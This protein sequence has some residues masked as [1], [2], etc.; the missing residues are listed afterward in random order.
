MTDLARTLFASEAKAADLSALA[1]DAAVK[2]MIRT[3][4]LIIFG[5]FA[6]IFGWGSTAHLD[7]AV[8]TFGVVQAEGSRKVVQHPD[9]GIINAILVKEGDLVQ[10][11]QI[12]I[13]LDPVQANAALNIQISDVDTLEASVAR[14]QAE[15]AGADKVVFPPDMTAR[16]ADPQVASIMATQNELF[17]ARHS[18]LV[19]D[20]GQLGEQVLQARSMADGYRG[21]MAAIDK[22]SSMIA[23]E[24]AGLQKLYAAGFATKPQVLAVER[25]ASALDGQKKEYMADI[26]RAGHA[27]GQYESQAAQLRRERVSD[28]SGQLEDARAK[29]ADAEQQKAAAQA[30]VDRT[31]IRAPATGFVFGLTANTIGAVIGRGEHIL[32]IVPSDAAPMVEAHLKPADGARVKKGM[33]VNLKVTASQGRALPVMSGVVKSRSVDLLSDE[34][35]G[36]AYYD[37]MIT[38]NRDDIVRAGAVLDVGTPVEVVVPTGSRTALHYLF[39]PLMEAFAHGLKE[40]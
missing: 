37:V 26:D 11:G 6:L 15:E 12:L 39:Q 40:P 23:D 25:A 35:T 27:M 17:H 13:R 1:G 7:S 16:A 14:L 32:E 31:S 22:Q 28:V 3:G 33:A 24:L 29:L 5:F 38:V 34:K 21:Q 8:T 20:G 36:Q 9:G 4:G 2:R 30:V 19:G 18:A 10:Q